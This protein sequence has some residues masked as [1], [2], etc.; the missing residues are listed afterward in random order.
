MD[1]RHMLPLVIDTVLQ[2]IPGTILRL[3][4]D[5]ADPHAGFQALRWVFPLLEKKCMLHHFLLSL[6]TFALEL[7]NSAALVI[8]PLRVHSNASPLFLASDLAIQSNFP[9]TLTFFLTM[10]LGAA[11]NIFAV[12]SFGQFV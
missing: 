6:Q 8:S 5:Q 10:V 3:Y 1:A 12:K 9:P 7:L 2:F 4:T 11:S